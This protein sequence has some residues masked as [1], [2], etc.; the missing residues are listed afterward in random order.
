MQDATWWWVICPA[1]ALGWAFV[2]WSWNRRAR[3]EKA[4]LDE[5]WGSLVRLNRLNYTPG[6]FS[7]WGVRS[8]FKKPIV[9]G[10]YRGRPLVLTVLGGS[11]ALYDGFVPIAATTVTLQIN[12]RLGC[13]LVLHEKGLLRRL[14]GRGK[15]HVEIGGLDPRFVVDGRPPVFVE[16]A[17]PILKLLSRERRTLGVNRSPFFWTSQ[18]KLPSIRLEQSQLT[19]HQYDVAI[20]TSELSELFNLL[21]ALADLAEETPAVA[22]AR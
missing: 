4:S 20:D 7:L 10:E 5:S 22:I 11:V 13:F 3:A 1:F 19:W 18:S 6:G 16:R 2:L 21:S 8:A 14:L 12:N 9:S 17:H 15:G